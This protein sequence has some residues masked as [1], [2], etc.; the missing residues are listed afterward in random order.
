MIESERSRPIELPVLTSEP[1]CVGCAFTYEDFA[2]SSA[3][4][5]LLAAEGC[6]RDCPIVTGDSTDLED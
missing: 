5:T 2:A 1:R 6:D 4:R 3:L